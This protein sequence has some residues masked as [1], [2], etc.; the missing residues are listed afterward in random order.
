M[1]DH[2][3]QKDILYKLIT[4]DGARFSEL[5]PK[6]VD[7]NV[8]T[9]HLKQLM[10]QKL[11][12]KADDGRYTL[13]ELGK[14]KGINITL[15]KKELLEQAHSIILMVLRDGDK[16]LLR[17]RKAQPMY[18]KI[19]FVHSEPIASTPVIETAKNE[20]LCRTGLTA[21]FSPRGFGYIRLMRGDN[22][23]SFVHF[24]LLEAKTY[25][26]K[27][28]EHARNGENLWIENPD[29]QSS[30]M[31]PSMQSFV[32][33]LDSPGIFYLDETYDIR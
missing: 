14:V 8:I 6:N 29:F 32:N 17:K 15:S 2:H 30:E 1:Q 9:Y 12:T 10:A 33:Q 13:T 11:I 3:I 7:S 26:G 21:D 23:E 25:S 22:L 18:D 27:L 4:S 28:Q 16:W 31:I 24:T 5:R 19:G 20:F